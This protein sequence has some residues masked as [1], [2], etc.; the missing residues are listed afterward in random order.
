[1]TALRMASCI[2]N[3]AADGMIPH[4]WRPPLASPLATACLVPDG[5]CANQ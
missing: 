4:L 2:L 1:M 5:Q 3:Y